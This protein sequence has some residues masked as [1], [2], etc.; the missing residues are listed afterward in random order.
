MRSYTILLNGIGNNVSYAKEEKQHR[1]HITKRLKEKE[2]HF[3][4]RSRNIS[5]HIKKIKK[6]TWTLF[7]KD[8]KYASHQHTYGTVEIVN[9]LK[10]CIILSDYDTTTCWQTGLVIFCIAH[11]ALYNFEW[12]PRRMQPSMRIICR[13]QRSVFFFL[14]KY[15]LDLKFYF[16]VLLNL[17]NGLI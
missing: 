9:Y 1:V 17:T 11:N 14:P 3:A 6:I 8:V 7:S 10:F 12:W 2:I 5:T 16:C 15:I 4:T 13:V